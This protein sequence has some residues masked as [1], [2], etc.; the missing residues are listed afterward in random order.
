MTVSGPQPSVSDRE[1]NGIK[2]AST[3]TSKVKGSGGQTFHPGLK[4]VNE[5]VYVPGLVKTCV[6]F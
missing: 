4:A 2:G 5:T 1:N 6:I 3:H